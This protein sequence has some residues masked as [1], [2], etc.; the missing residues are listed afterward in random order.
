MTK[1]SRCVIFASVQEQRPFHLRLLSEEFTR[2]KQK[3]AHFSQRAFAQKLDIPSGVLSALLSGKRFMSY[4]LGEKIISKLDCSPQTAEHFLISIVQEQSKRSLL[5]RDPKIRLRKDLA[6]KRTTFVLDESVY[7]L[8]GEWYH[9][10]ILELSYKKDFKCHPEY[11]SD[12]LGIKLNTAKEAL[13]RLFDLGLLV[14]END[15]VQKRHQHLDCNNNRDKAI[16]RRRKQIQMREKAIEAI[17]S[18]DP[19]RRYMTTVM[20]CIDPDLLDEAKRRIDEF[21]DS[22]CAFLESGKRK[23][24]F[25]MEVGIFSLEK[26]KELK[27]TPLHSTLKE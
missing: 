23:E 1:K 11:V 6:N 3:N 13:A 19:E 16:A 24:V 14:R 12:A 8:I 17:E 7:H 25:C 5:R 9:D 26:N 18:Q 22:L 4:S 27:M 15:S 20:M 21:N 2:R 10:A